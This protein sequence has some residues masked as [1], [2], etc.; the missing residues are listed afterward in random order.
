MRLHLH[1]IKH[2][3][4][5]PVVSKT[6]LAGFVATLSMDLWAY[7]L[8][9]MV[10]TSISWDAIGR[11]VGHLLMFNLN[12]HHINDLTPLP[13]E[14][15]YGWIFHYCVGISYACLYVFIKRDILH[16][17]MTWYSALFFSW[18]M[19]FFPL[20]FLSALLGEGL[21]YDHTINQWNNLLYTFSCHSAFG[22]G[23]MVC[24]LLFHKKK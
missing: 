22:L 19:M 11:I 15:I 12:I 23:L 8:H 16:K 5:L 14:N 17:A 2:A 24:L 18:A 9:V 21:F 20:I 6:L 10:G 1:D 3:W 4:S 13:Y 7:I